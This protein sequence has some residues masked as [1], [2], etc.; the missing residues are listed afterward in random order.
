MAKVQ[1][2]GRRISLRGTSRWGMYAGRMRGKE[3][4]HAGSGAGRGADT[5][6]GTAASPNSGGTIRGNSGPRDDARACKRM[7]ISR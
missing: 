4:V 3:G 2:L 6:G 1:H 7:K 5:R